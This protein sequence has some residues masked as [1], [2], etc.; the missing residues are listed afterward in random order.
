LNLNHGLLPETPF[1][2]VLAFIQAA[3][4]VRPPR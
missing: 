2:N 3:R 4:A 1:A